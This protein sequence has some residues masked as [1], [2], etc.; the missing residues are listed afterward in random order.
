[1]VRPHKISSPALATTKVAQ[2]SPGPWI[3]NAAKSG[4]AGWWVRLAGAAGKVPHWSW[5]GMQVQT[6]LEMAAKRCQRWPGHVAGAG[7]ARIRC[8]KMVV[9]RATRCTQIAFAVFMVQ[10]GI[11]SIPRTFNAFYLIW[12]RIPKKRIIERIIIVGFLTFAW[13][14]AQSCQIVCNP[15]VMVAVFLALRF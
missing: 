7:R 12:A 4:A 2:P 13:T 5:S 8:N 14:N 1:M 10:L 9:W 3:C 6:A 11:C 15:F